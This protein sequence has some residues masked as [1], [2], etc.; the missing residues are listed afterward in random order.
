[1][2]LRSLTRLES[3]SRASPLTTRVRLQ[4]RTRPQPV[5]AAHWIRNHHLSAIRLSSIPQATSS[6]T[7]LSPFST[8]P[9]APRGSHIRLSRLPTS[10]STSFVRYCSYRRHNMCRLA[11]DTE[12]FGG[13]NPDPTMGRELLPTNV[14]PT[15]YDVT[16]EPDFQKFTFEGKV[17]IDFDVQEDT[18]SISLHTIE[19]DIHSAHIKSGDAVVTSSSAIT[20]DEATQ[21][22]KIDLKD[23]VPK[24][25]TQLEIKF[26]GQLNDSMAGFYRSTYKKPDGSEGILATTQMEANDC[27]RAFP[28]FDEPLHKAKFTITLI[29]DKNLTCLSN[30]DVASETEVTSEMSGT[31][32]KAVKFNPTPLMSTYLVAFI[33]GELNYIETKKFRVPIRVYAPPSSNIEHGQFSLELAAR[34]LEYYEKIFDADFPLP[35]MDMVAIPD[36]AAGAMENWGL[37]TYRVVDL[38]LDEKASGAAMKERV[39]EVVQHELAHQWFGNLVTMDWWE[40]LWLNE[41]F[42]TLMSW[43][44]CNH[45][46]PEWKVWENYVADNLQSAL[47]LDS[48]RSSHPIE[49]PVKRASEV[50]QIFDAISYSKGSCVLR[51]ISTYLGEDV[52]LEG[53][54]R[55]IK[56]HAYGNTQ[57]DDL[58]AALEDASG[59]P[60]REIMSIWTKNVGFPVVQ[61]TENAAENSILVKQNRFLRTGDTKPEEDKVL[62]P[63]FLGLRTKTGVDESLTLTEREGV[64]K[65]PDLDFFKLNANHTSIYRTSYS[66]ERLTKLGQSAKDG[67]LTVEDR[68]GMIADA[69]ALAVS[70]YQKTSGVL[71]LLKGFDTEDSF[72]VWSEI[73]ARVATVQSAWIFEDQAV[74]DGLEAFVKELVSERAHKLGWSFSDK[75]GHVEQ[76]FKA[77]LFGAAG[78]AGDREII[79]AAKD[80]FTKYKAGDKSAIHPN[81]RGSVFGIALK[82]GGKE[83]YD[84]IMDIF[85]TSNNTDERN[86]A[87]RCVGRAKDPELIQRTLEFTLGNEVKSQDIYLPTSGL[88]SHA[89][90]VEALFSWLTEKWPEIYKRL[91]GNP[92]ILGSMVTICTSSFAKPE[93]LE[94]VEKFFR[95]IDTKSFDQPLA[96]S[97][98][99]IRS[100]ISWLQRDRDDVATW[101]KENGYKKANL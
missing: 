69:G 47:G 14:I 53:V 84:A 46:Y 55:Y 24:G 75:D 18:K 21:V 35:K 54:R 79:T 70:G 76:Q 57:T 44:S 3:V 15:H 99:A 20:Y 63:V 41:G 16:L 28:C 26:T 85:R 48:L 64:Y 96:Q 95:D 39:A 33:I 23:A 32:K 40:G 77:M 49:V 66:P 6:T 94:K 25:K 91:S 93:Q 4:H 74:K 89:E 83:E 8:P 81:I 52:F 86:T 100:K 29:A 61:V 45:F 65:L 72:V 9:R 62:Y 27:R 38:M 98:D 90:G 73:I 10:I 101:V 56:K 67:K 30:M 60:V 7:S 13:A 43:L 37:I 11:G 51:M 5:H 59:K 87:L 12:H 92:P 80:M 17:V 78:M 36:F 88:R 82:Y 31:T 19:I 42:A 22:S 34:T 50:D 71:N 97:K 68:A 2:S 58:W 1:M